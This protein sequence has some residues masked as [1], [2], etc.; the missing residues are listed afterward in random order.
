[1][2]SGRIGFRIRVDETLADAATWVV[3]LFDVRGQLVLTRALPL[4][5]GRAAMVWDGRDRF[6][7]PAAAGVYF[8]VAA[9]GDHSAFTSAVLLR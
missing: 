3:E 5:N 2:G 8:A 1:L 7:R 4:V 6:G 9:V